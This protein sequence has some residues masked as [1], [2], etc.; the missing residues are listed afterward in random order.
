LRQIAVGN[1]FRAARGIVFVG[2]GTASTGA[3]FSWGRRR[4]TRDGTRVGIQMNALSKLL[5]QKQQLIERLQEEIG[6]EERDEIERL[7]ENIDAA[8]DSL[9]KAGPESARQR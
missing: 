8:L 4:S 7:L 9:E 3:A 5:S 2:P 6:P 1:K